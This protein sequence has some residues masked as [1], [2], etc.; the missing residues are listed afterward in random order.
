MMPSVKPVNKS[1]TLNLQNQVPLKSLSFKRKIAVVGMG[2]VGLMIAAAFGAKNKVIGYDIS[3]K[4]IDALRAGNDINGELNKEELAKTLIQFTTNSADLE[5]ADFYIIAVPT[6][7]ND[8]HP[9]LSMLRT[10]SEMVATYLKKGDIVVYES[11]VYP[12]ATEEHTIP[13]LEKTSGLICGKDFGLGYSPERIN[14]ADKEHTMANIPKIVSGINEATLNVVAQVYSSIIP[15]GVHKVSSI[16]AAEAT[17]VIENIQRDLNISYV[18]EIAKILHSLNLSSVEIFEAM[19]TKWNH[20]PFRPGLVGGHC[21]PVNSY[22]LA[23]VAE[24]S[25]CYPEMILAARRVNE[26]MPKYVAD[27]TI[28]ELIHLDKQIKGARIGI[29][30]LSYK[31]NT[32]D[33]HDTQITNLINELKSFDTEILVYDPVADAGSAKRV[34]GIDLVS[35]DDLKDLDAIIIGVAHNEFVTMD[36]SK[37]KTL[38]KGKGLVVDLKGICKSQDFKDSNISLWQL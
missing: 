5:K 36:K 33:V 26:T 27:S 38:F 21:I 23:H 11:S 18:N 29:F 13:V 22:Y 12:G 32:P 8:K 9:D 31:E 7:L 28:K 30:G 1:Q 25:G 24:E 17:K 20:L 34:H 6:P 14:P 15:A 4:R 2:Y 35:W 16:R 3:Q 37:L 10:A 19:K